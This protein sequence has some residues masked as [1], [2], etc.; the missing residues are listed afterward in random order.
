MTKRVLTVLLCILVM[1]SMAAAAQILILK[2][3]YKNG[4]I[5]L[6]EKIVK[7]GFSP[8]YKLFDIDYATLL[9]YNKT[10]GIISQLR[11]E[12]PTK[13]YADA[14]TPEGMTGGIVERSEFDFAVVMP[15]DASVARI[16]IVDFKGKT[17]FNEK[18]SFYNETIGLRNVFLLWL[19][20]FIVLLVIV[21]FKKRR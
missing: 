13:L 15:Y 4:G 10:D 18:I 20:G 5:T 21:Y 1:S 17:L 2:F 16:E 8:D 6:A 12:I 3:H 19:G 11:F 9:L 7:D 14:M